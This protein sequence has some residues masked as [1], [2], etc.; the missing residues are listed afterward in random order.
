MIVGTAVGM[1]V[2]LNSLPMAPREDFAGDD[3]PVNVEREP[4][5]VLN[6]LLADEVGDGDTD[7]VE[8]ELDG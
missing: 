7:A 4:E 5:D 3:Q 6:A 1:A 8:P 2:D